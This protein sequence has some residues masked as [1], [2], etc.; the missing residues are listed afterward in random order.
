MSTGLIGSFIS[1]IFI[2]FHNIKESA[3]SD[4]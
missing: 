3:L 4:D 2:A 1:S